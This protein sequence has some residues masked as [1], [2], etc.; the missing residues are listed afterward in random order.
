MILLLTDFGTAGPYVRQIRAVPA[1]EAPDVSVIELFA[2]APECNPRASAYLLGAYRQGFAAGDNFLAVVDPGVG[3]DRVAEAHWRRIAWRLDV[4]SASFHGRDLFAPVAARLAL[5]HSPTGIERPV[6]EIRQRDWPEDL[7][8]VIYIDG[9]GNAMTGLRASGVPATARIVVKGTE[10]DHA[11]TFSD[12][13]MGEAF[14]YENANGLVEIAVS[15]GN[16]A[17]TF[18]LAVGTEVTIT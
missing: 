4:L 6:D 9:F 15:R 3:G 17:S 11:R 13:S 8:Q 7:S 5:R 16:A 1:R 2:N 18:G 14:W 12:V 10:I